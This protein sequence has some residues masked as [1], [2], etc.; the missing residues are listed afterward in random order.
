MVTSRSKYI[1]TFRLAATVLLVIYLVFS[2]GCKTPDGSEPA[3]PPV[4]PEPTKEPAP[5][6]TKEP[7]P[8][9]TKEPAPEPTKEPTPE[10]TK[11]PAPEPTKEPDPE[12][13]VYTTL[14]DK[15]LIVFEGKDSG[16]SDYDIYVMNPDGSFLTKLTRSTNDDRYPRWSPDGSKIAYCTKQG[17]KWNICVMNADGTGS[18]VLTE[19]LYNDEYPAWSPDG[20]KLV[21]TSDRLKGHE[22]HVMD[23]ATGENMVTLTSD[24]YY[25]QYP[26]WSPDGAYITHS[27]W[28][29]GSFDIY[30]I[31]AG[32]GGLELVVDGRGNQMFPRYSPQGDR[33]SYSTDAGN[34]PTVYLVSAP[35][36]DTKTGG[37]PGTT[38]SWTADGNGHLVETVTG[39]KQAFITITPNGDYI[40]HI[41]PGLEIIGFPHQMPDPT[42]QPPF[43]IP[44]Q[45]DAT[46]VKWISEFSLTGSR[47][48][49]FGKV[50]NNHPEYSLENVAVIIR[51]L[52]E[53]NKLVQEL[54][55][56]VGAGT[57]GPGDNRNYKSEP[58]DQDSYK[59]YTQW[60][61]YT[62]KTS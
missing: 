45:I 22:I 20:K 19:S 36:W 43:Q 61:T 31:M 53:N 62:W 38:P 27:A 58:I 14:S 40:N 32:G 59:V 44:D 52:D 1:A 13:V 5:E 2:I 11:E 55:I 51:L 47:I 23:A 24:N 4:A 16:N 30:R 33:I 34:T 54:S 41:V 25:Q 57:L 35:D 10:P 42:L 15:G 18:K 26:D 12:P 49:L 48:T 3:A 9:P 8:E 6:P 39:T 17:D 60:L 56:P 7:T 37:T 46:K 21:F 29:A 28:H 50:V